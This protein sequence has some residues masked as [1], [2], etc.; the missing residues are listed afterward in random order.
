MDSNLAV[1]SMSKSDERIPTRVSWKALKNDATARW[2]LLKEARKVSGTKEMIPVLYD[3]VRAVATADPRA[4]EGLREELS[5]ILTA[6]GMELDMG[7]DEA[8]VP[9]T[10]IAV[11]ESTAV[12]EASARP[13]ARAS[14]TQPSGFAR[15]R[16][17]PQFAAPLPAAETV[18][19][20]ESVLQVKT[21][22]TVGV[23]EAVS[24]L[25]VQPEI[26]Q[27]AQAEMASLD[28]MKKGIE[29][30]KQDI[31][32][33]RWMATLEGK[34]P[35]DQEYAA[36]LNAL[37]EL[38]NPDTAPIED[39]RQA[40]GRFARA[41]EPLFAE[42]QSVSSEVADA[43]QPESA[44]SA[45]ASTTPLAGTPSW[46][47]TAEVT[48]N[49]SPPSAPSE[50]TAPGAPGGSPEAMPTDTYQA[51]ISPV[52]T[53]TAEPAP[54]AAPMAETRDITQPRD[55]E[56]PTETASGEEAPETAQT[57]DD[58]TVL[59]MDP[60]VTAGLKQLLSEWG[61]FKS[62][63]WFGM[64]AGGIEHSLYKKLAGLPVM[65]VVS[66]RWEG[67]DPKITTN[68][69][70]YMDGWKKEFGIDA[71]PEEPFETYLRRVIAEIL[72]LTSEPVSEP[73]AA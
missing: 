14:S 61:L 11:Q 45:S 46:G 21:E 2:K 17:T 9:I 25:Q 55:A 64:G 20:D 44:V 58:E 59:L 65:T 51:P 29:K 60:E 73:L 12:P 47:S 24:A 34:S 67:A 41:A 49:A 8:T 37:N 6:L 52:E 26:Q 15:P 30:I 13:E 27:S 42:R 19:P 50:N 32:F 3:K 56:A 54:S 7:A 31:G 43:N 57:E 10:E 38:G 63:G 33:Q 5:D 22:P 48:Q 1:E 4:Q 69:T 72:H 70:E 39:F 40:Y 66:G 35:A 16:P 53:A 36:A 23:A 62:S 28:E 18:I 71:D 68:I